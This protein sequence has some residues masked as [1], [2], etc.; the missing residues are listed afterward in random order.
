MSMVT[1]LVERPLMTNDWSRVVKNLKVT[2]IRHLRYHSNSNFI[3]NSKMTKKGQL[4]SILI[5]YGNTSLRPLSITRQM[6]MLY[7]ILYILYSFKVIHIFCIIA[8]DL[9]VARV[10][11]ASSDGYCFPRIPRCGNKSSCILLNFDAYLKI[12]LIFSP[13]LFSLSLSVFV[14]SHFK[15]TLKIRDPRTINGRSK[16]RTKI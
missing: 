2:E 8:L 6:V 11:H 3:L 14:L 4:R 1:S 7:S 12:V 16:D 5:V 9:Q 15:K 10:V 13:S